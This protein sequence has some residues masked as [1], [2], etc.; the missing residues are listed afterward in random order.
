MSKL[1]GAEVLLEASFAVHET[2]VV[3]SGNVA[4]EE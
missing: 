3:P 4:P 2:V 1:A